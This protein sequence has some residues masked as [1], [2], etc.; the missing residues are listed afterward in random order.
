L[1]EETLKGALE[2]VIPRHPVVQLGDGSSERDATS[3]HLSY[4]IDWRV[5]TA[6]PTALNQ[7]EGALA[8]DIA[9]LS[10]PASSNVDRLSSSRGAGVPVRVADEVLSSFMEQEWWWPKEEGADSKNNDRAGGGGS[11]GEETVLFVLA[12]RKAKVFGAEELRRRRYHYLGAGAA[13]GVGPGCVSA[14]VGRGRYLAVDLS[15]G[16]CEWGND[17]HASTGGGGGGGGGATGL[18][19]APHVGDGSQG[20]QSVL[21]AL[22][23]RPAS[24]SYDGRDEGDDD[25]D[26]DGD[27]DVGD[28]S[29]SNGEEEK[30]KEEASVVDAEEEEWAATHGLKLADEDRER[31]MA[32]R[33]QTAES[34]KLKQEEEKEEE[35]EEEAHVLSRRRRTILTAQVLSK[36][37]G[38]CAITTTNPAASD[39]ELASLLYLHCM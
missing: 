33:R 39:I 16:P 24:I 13:A 12:P 36:G 23:L 17:D 3:S 7:L 22:G 21:E 20:A 29:F 5:S 34:S 9:S 27:G 37:Q 32:R 28:Y 25:D 38:R 31:V 15:A 10:T 19:S 14:W 26:D 8:A 30:E 2:E 18:F 11:G 4:A 6:P 35:E 1:D